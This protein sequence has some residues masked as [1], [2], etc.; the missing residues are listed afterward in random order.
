M[1]PETIFEPRMTFIFLQLKKYN[2]S[3]KKKEANP[4]EHRKQRVLKLGKVVD[5]LRV[6]RVERSNRA[7]WGVI[8]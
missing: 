5:Q 1:K 3:N 7:K 4:N 8:V 2:Q 6:A